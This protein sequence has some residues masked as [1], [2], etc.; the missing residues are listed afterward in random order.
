MVKCQRYRLTEDDKLGG[1]CTFDM[2]FVEA[3]VQ[4]FMPNTDTAEN[5]RAQSD[6]LKTQVAAV[7]ANQRA[8]TPGQAQIAAI[9]MQLISRWT[10]P[11]TNPVR[12]G[13]L[14]R[15]TPMTMGN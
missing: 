10:G 13:L 8:L 9:R 7:W 4:P 14:N 3:G 11:A 5:L 1:Y 6:A 15:W 12:M 2:Q